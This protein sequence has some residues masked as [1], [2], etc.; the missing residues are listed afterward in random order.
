MD[1]LLIYPP[2][3]VNERYGQ[4]VGKV[5]GNLPPLGVTQIASFVREKGLEV[6]LI[7]AVGDGYNMEE[8]VQKSLE[9]N[10]KM[11]GISSLSSNFHRVIIFAQEI[12]KKNPD[13]LI[14]LGG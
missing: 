13:I 8:L 4:N 3:S 5:G 12:K 10:P 14:V 6:G 7:D 2:I 11:I 1:L 9:L